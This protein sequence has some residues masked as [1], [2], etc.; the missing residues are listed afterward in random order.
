[1]AGKHLQWGGK[2]GKFALLVRCQVLLYDSPQ[3]SYLVYQETKKQLLVYN[4]AK[5]GETVNGVRYQVS[6]EFFTR[7][8]SIPWTSENSLFGGFHHCGGHQT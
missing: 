1:M 5:N 6:N 3:V 8:S 2:L 7:A 4:F